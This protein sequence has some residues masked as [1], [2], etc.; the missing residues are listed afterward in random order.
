MADG[1]I[2]WRAGLP[3][4]GLRSSP[5]SLTL[6][7][8]TLN[9]NLNHQTLP[10]KKARYENSRAFLRF[11]ILRRVSGFHAGCGATRCCVFPWD[12]AQFSGKLM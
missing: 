10:Q 9:L 6:D 5:N 8:L 12:C 3:R 4:V 7:S 2:V 1:L 11:W